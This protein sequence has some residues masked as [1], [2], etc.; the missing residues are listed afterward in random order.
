MSIEP[1][2]TAS[3]PVPVTI[4]AQYI[5]DFSFENPNAPQIFAPSQAAPDI[6]MGVN[7]HTRALGASAYEVL[8]ALKIEAKLQGKTAF[9][10]ELVYGG[11][12]TLPQMPEEQL[13]LFLLIEA[14][15]L[16]FPFARGVLSTAIR[17][18]G[19]P[20]V[21]ISP[22]DFYSLYLANKDKVGSMP[23]AGAA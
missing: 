4:T 5:K 1:N 19:F 8:L 3:Q 22:I 11:V 23:A 6:S 15:R 12:F 21:I 9:I 7:V 13:R 2:Q 16:L 18:G 20:Q 17:E 10:S 14:P